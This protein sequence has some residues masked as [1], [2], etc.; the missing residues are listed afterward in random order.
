MGRSHHFLLCL[1]NSQTSPTSPGRFCPA[2][3]RNVLARLPEMGLP[4]SIRIRRPRPGCQTQPLAL[5]TA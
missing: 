2:D 3:F 1:R 5:R 4:H